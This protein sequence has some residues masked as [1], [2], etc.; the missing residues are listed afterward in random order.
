MIFDVISGGSNYS[1]NLNSVFETKGKTFAP[2]S[3]TN[4]DTHKD[5]GNRDDID[6][7]TISDDCFVDEDNNGNIEDTNKLMIKIDCL[8]SELQT[9]QQNY[10]NLQQQQNKLKE[11]LIG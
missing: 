4:N 8:D 7:G 10:S 11:K 9:I 5:I 3:N 6:N 2:V 1:V